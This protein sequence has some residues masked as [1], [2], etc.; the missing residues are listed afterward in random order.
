MKEEIIKL[1][2]KLKKSGAS[3]NEAK[4]QVLDLFAVMETFPTYDICLHCQKEYPV[5]AGSICPDCFLGNVP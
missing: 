3:I 1:L 4:Q 5:S 2:E